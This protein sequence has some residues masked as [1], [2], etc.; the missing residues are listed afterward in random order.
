MPKKAINRT[1]INKV[2]KHLR[3]GHTAAE[4]ARAYNIELGVVEAFTEENEEKV[5]ESIRDAENVLHLEDKIAKD[6]LA[7]ATAKRRNSALKAAATRKRKAEEQ[8]ALDAAG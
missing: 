1:M 5:R 8:A 2:Q 4:I 6:E 7:E 3:Q